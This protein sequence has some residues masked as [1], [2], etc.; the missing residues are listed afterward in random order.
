MTKLLHFFCLALLLFP[1]MAWGECIQGDCINGF[2]IY[3]FPEG[4]QYA[5]QF[6]EGKFAGEGSQEYADGKRYEGMFANSSPHG[7]GKLIYSDGSIYTGDFEHGAI[8][9]QGAIVFA[10]GSKYDGTFKNGLFSGTGVYTFADGS[11]YKGVFKNN[12]F[13]GK[14]TITSDG[15][16]YVG[17]FKEGEYY[18]KG[19]ITYYDKSREIG[20]WQ[21]GKFVVSQKIK[22]PT[23]KKGTEDV[24]Q[25]FGNDDFKTQ[26]T[27][28]MPEDQDNFSA[29]DG[30]QENN[31]VTE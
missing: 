13:N 4:G 24:G 21:D 31:N 15:Q 8:T 19:T 3:I 22:P 12:L 9:G 18:G 23:Q 17:E 6:S 2:G 25:D 7:E 28:S 16:I 11:Q 29:P 27:W 5:G 30:F 10:D 14:G 20:E 26:D 1:A